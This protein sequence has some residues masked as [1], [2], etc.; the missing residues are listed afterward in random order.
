MFEEWKKLG[1]LSKKAEILSQL[2]AVQK[3]D[4]E[5][6]FHIEYLIDN[7]LQLSPQEK[8]ENSRY[9]QEIQ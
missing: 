1:N 4:G 8:E 5:P 3:A 9:I 7:V 2:T 6:Y